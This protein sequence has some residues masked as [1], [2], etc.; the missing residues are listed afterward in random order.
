MRLHMRLLA[1][2]TL[3]SGPGFAQPAKHGLPKAVAASKH[4]EVVLASADRM[5]PDAPAIVQPPSEPRRPA[6]RITHCRCGDPQPGDE[7]PEQ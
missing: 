4:V 1:M 3:T 7:T 6:P 5:R 2:L